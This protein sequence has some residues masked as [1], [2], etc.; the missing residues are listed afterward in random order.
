MLWP[1]SWRTARLAS[2]RGVGRWRPI[3]Q[4]RRRAV[5]W[6]RR[7]VAQCSPGRRDASSLGTPSPAGVAPACVCHGALDRQTC[8]ASG[9]TRCTALPPGPCQCRSGRTSPAIL[10]QRLLS[11]PRRD[12]ADGVARHRSLAPW[13]PCWEPEHPNQGPGGS[14]GTGARFSAHEIASTL[15]GRLPAASQHARPRGGAWSQ[16]RSHSPPSGAVHHRP[17]GTNPGRSRTVAA[18]GG[19]WPTLLESVLAG[20]ARARS[21]PPTTAIRARGPRAVRRP[22]GPGRRGLRPGRDDHVPARPAGLCRHRRR[23]RMSWR[24]QAPDR[25]GHAIAAHLPA[26]TAAN[27][28]EMGRQ[29]INDDHVCG[30]QRPGDSPS[31][32][33]G[34]KTG[35][36]KP[37]GCLLTW[38]NAGLSVNP[39]EGHRV[40]IPRLRQPDS[41]SGLKGGR[42]C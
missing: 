5:R 38:V 39:S 20:R 12:C 3:A 32:P 15:I 6:K 11:V 37:F 10:R 13:P 34:S 40:H 35:C 25:I 28:P 41:C 21:I 42:Q 8:R 7:C 1:L 18:L 30:A 29:R 31:L 26:E 17:P 16:F 27:G 24:G 14:A 9:C 23:M 33:S 22:A 36:G 4:R 2:R 19:R